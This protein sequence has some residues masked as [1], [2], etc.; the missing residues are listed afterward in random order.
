M[1][2]AAGV[3][4]PCVSPQEDFVDPDKD[5][6]IES[7]FVRIKETPS[8]QESTVFYVADDGGRAYTVNQDTSHPPPSKVFVCDKPAS[9]KEPRPGGGPGP[10]PAD[11][12]AE[13]TRK[14]TD[15]G[16]HGASGRTCSLSEP[17]PESSILSR[18]D[19]HRSSSLPAKKTVHF[20]TDVYKDASCSKDPGH[21]HD[22]GFEGSL[23]GSRDSWR[24][25][26]PISE[27]EERPKQDGPTAPD[28]AL[29]DVRLAGSKTGPSPT[30]QGSVPRNRASERLASLGEESCPWSLLGEETVMADSSEVK[31][32]L[33]TVEAV[34]EE[35]DFEGIP[36]KASK[37]NS[38]LVDFAS[39]SQVFG[40]EPPP[41]EDGSAGTEDPEEPAEKLGI[42]RSRSAHRMEGADEPPGKTSHEDHS[43]VVAAEEEAARRKPEVYEKAKCKSPRPPRGEEEAEAEDPPALEG[44]LPS[45]PPSSQVSLETLGSHSEEGLDFKRS[46]PLSKVSVIPHNLFYYP[47]Y[48]VPL[49]A[50]LEAYAEG[51]EDLKTE[52]MDFED[53]EDY[54][55][56]LEQRED[57]DG[58]EPS[59][60]SGSFGGLGEDLSYPPTQEPDRDRG[61]QGPTPASGPT[62]ALAPED[63]QQKEAKARAPAE[64]QQVWA[65]TWGVLPLRAQLL[66]QHSLPPR[67]G[68]RLQF[69]FGLWRPP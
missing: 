68:A 53:P 38:D 55:S 56:D 22:F 29:D 46:P 57:E 11:S 19:S 50:V 59:E 13:V 7:T 14:G 17:P 35:D 28:K 64:S 66:S 23:R 36:L 60:S 67:R 39:T 21:S 15:W 52:D 26:E 6:P 62:P 30:P 51:P 47:H 16:A 44:D 61:A 18:K 69:R 58:P 25:D 2:Q 43:C 27:A 20:E 63:Q 40:E 45:N 41:P 10:A 33:G 24:Q 1:L 54:L 42:R 5:A 3:M 48:E 65:A 9:G 32:R 4:L 31:G 34:D 12:P 8:E 37:F 49:A